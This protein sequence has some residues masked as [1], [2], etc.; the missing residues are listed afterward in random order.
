MFASF[1]ADG[2][3]R[4]TAT[5]SS[6]RPEGPFQPWSDGP[7]TPRGAVALDGTLHIDPAGVPWMIYC[8]EWMQLNDGAI[9]AIQLSDDLR[10]TVAEPVR[11]FHGS[12]AP[13]VR[14]LEP[15][16]PQEAPG[17]DKNLSGAKQ[18]VTDGP[19]LHRTRSAPS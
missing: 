18:Y 19:F 5:L 8:H 2:L 17:P 16:N 6:D 14:T 12:H 13:W 9:S 3:S 7:I 15:A 4:G 1:R 10:Q 11:L